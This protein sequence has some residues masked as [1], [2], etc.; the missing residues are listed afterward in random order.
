[1]TYRII[2]RSEWGARYGDGF[3]DRPVGDLERWLHHSVTIAPDLVPPWT[4]DYAAVRELEAI[5]QSRFA[6]GISYT[7]AITPAG[8][9][10]QGHSIDRVGS[11]TQGHN[12]AGAGIVLVGNYENVSPAPQ[13]LAAVT[14][15][16]HEGVRRGWWTSPTLTGGH[17]DTKGTA[18]PGAKAYELIPAINRGAYLNT[19]STGGFMADLTEQEK[20]DF[21]AD[22]KAIRSAVLAPIKDGDGAAPPRVIAE[23]TLDVSRRILA[24]QLAEA[25]VPVNV[26]IDADHVADALLERLPTETARAVVD[27]L[28]ARLAQ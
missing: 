10:F 13:Q 23:R 27:T 24:N 4:D 3:Y 22:I 9:I 15:L 28:T 14:W 26:E 1:V 6:G 20:D 16:L 17:R 8:L 2:P 19:P 25:A 7:F 21:L 5:G 11:H 12:T 18:C